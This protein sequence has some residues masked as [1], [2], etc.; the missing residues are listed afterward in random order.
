MLCGIYILVLSMLSND[1]NALYYTQGNAG[2]CSERQNS[3]PAYVFRERVQHLLE[4]S[5]EVLLAIQL[6][7]PCAARGG[8]HSVQVLV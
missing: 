5:H 2:A 8:I 4:V 1:R 7:G 3:I 6:A